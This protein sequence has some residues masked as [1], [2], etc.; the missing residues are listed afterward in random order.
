MV[1]LQKWTTLKFFFE[2]NPSNDDL[3]YV[4]RCSCRR[5]K[6]MLFGKLSSFLFT[7]SSLANKITFVSNKND[8]HVMIG[9]LN[10]QHPPTNSPQG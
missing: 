2:Q 7:N 8:T 10:V 4:L 9:I 1:K 3:L 5:R 6:A